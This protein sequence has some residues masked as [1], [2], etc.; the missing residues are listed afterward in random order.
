MPGLAS[1]L[2]QHLE[3][4]LLGD[5]RRFQVVRYNGE[6]TV[7]SGIRFGQVAILALAGAE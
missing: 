5:S 6:H 4:E 1:L 3:G 2:Q 7:F